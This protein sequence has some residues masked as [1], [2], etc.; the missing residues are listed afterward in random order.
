MSDT[1]AG[2]ATALTEQERRYGLLLSENLALGAE[3]VALREALRYA[4]AT[5]REATPRV[6]ALATTLHAQ[7]TELVALRA[8]A[9]A[10]AGLAE[11]VR[12]WSVIPYTPGRDEEYESETSRAEDLILDGLTQ[13]DA[14]RTGGIATRQPGAPDPPGAAPAAEAGG[15]YASTT[16]Q[17]ADR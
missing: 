9:V 12:A 5:A 10:A 15:C 14:V 7:H 1:A 4:L 6:Q 17:G 3:L 16:R 2:E 11:R 8:V 13:Y